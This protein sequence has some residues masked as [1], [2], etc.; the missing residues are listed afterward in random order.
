MA[1]DITDEDRANGQDILDG[2]MINFSCY[3][4]NRQQ[5]EPHG[6]WLSRQDQS[7]EIMNVTCHR[8]YTKRK[9]RT[10][11]VEKACRAYK[12]WFGFIGRF[13]AG[14]KAYS[15]FDREW[16]WENARPRVVYRP[17]VNP[18]APPNGPVRTTGPLRRG[19]HVRHGAKC[20][21][22]GCEHERKSYTKDEMQERIDRMTNV[23]DFGINIEDAH[24]P[25]CMC[26]TCLVG[27]GDISPNEARAIAQAT[28]EYSPHG[29]RPACPCKRCYDWRRVQEFKAADQF[30]TSVHHG[31][32][33]I[34]GFGITDRPMNINEPVTRG[35]LPDT[36]PGAPPDIPCVDST[37]KH[38]Q[39]CPPDSHTSA[40][41]SS[42][43]SSGGSNDL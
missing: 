34:F 38:S 1:R 22:P 8:C 43:S 25:L 40:P 10:E 28:T 17:A 36:P 23:N 35:V 7:K 16:A 32:H 9:E 31:D 24:S 11:A 6:E 41:D 14:W 19:P 33:R 5:D 3:Y 13:F 42:P 39:S 15:K 2:M 27:R 37:H 21:C 29:H 26:I 20:I 30:A 12:G 18:V 4:C